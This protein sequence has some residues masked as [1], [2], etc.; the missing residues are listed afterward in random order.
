M[1]KSLHYYGTEETFRAVW[2]S[3]LLGKKEMNEKE[4]MMEN[5]GLKREIEEITLL[6]HGG[7]WMTRVL[8][9]N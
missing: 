2:I 9:R 6:G 1:T 3:S 5:G 8:M 7:I 4:R